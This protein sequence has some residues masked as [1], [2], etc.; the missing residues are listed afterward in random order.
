VL[1]LDIVV[2]REIDELRG[3]TLTLWA[4]APRAL[5]INPAAPP[6]APAFKAGDPPFDERFKV[7]GSTMAFN[8]LFDDDL[9]ARTVATLDGWLAYWEHEG[10]RYR[11]YPGRAA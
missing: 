8:A 2:G 4:I 11:L 10:V 5:G 1:A 3:A 9:R 7:R 6:A